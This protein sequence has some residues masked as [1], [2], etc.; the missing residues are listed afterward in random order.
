M[1]VEPLSSYSAAMRSALG[2]LC[3]LRKLQH[4]AVLV[5]RE[6]RHGLFPRKASELAAQVQLCVAIFFDYSARVLDIGPQVALDRLC[7]DD[8]I[9]LLV[10]VLG[11]FDK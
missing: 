8:S 1:T 10:S 4:E 7:P 11:R 2:C 6:A 3:V 5:L 9:L